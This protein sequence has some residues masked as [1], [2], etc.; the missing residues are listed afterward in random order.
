ME[1]NWDVGDKNSRTANDPVAICDLSISKGMQV[2]KQQP[3][4]HVTPKELDYLES[5][6]V[7]G[8]NRA[9]NG[10]AWVC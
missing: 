5:N 7:L 9:G 10:T 6:K 8:T 3:P 1:T 4:Q 2:V